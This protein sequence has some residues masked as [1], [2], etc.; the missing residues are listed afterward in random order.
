MK[1]LLL[2]LL[3]PLSLLAQ[4]IIL[5]KNS[6][7]YLGSLKYPTYML[8]IDNNSASDPAK[9]FVTTVKNLKTLERL[10]PKYYFARKQE[11]NEYYILGV[12]NLYQ[13]KVVEKALTTYL[14]QIDNSRMGRKR[15]TFL[16]VYTLDNS[17]NEIIYQGTFKNL[18][19]VDNVY[20]LKRV[21]D[22][23]RYMICPSS[24]QNAD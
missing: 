17:K 13:T 7:L 14:T 4:K 10:I 6:T 3:L 18:S 11:Y 1:T 5:E 12:P 16:R 20:Y 23:C 21:Q 22:I 9:V 19:K 8:R 24:H 15:S 2:L